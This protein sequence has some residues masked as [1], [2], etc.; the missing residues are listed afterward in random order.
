MVKCGLS[1]SIHKAFDWRRSPGLDGIQH[2]LNM[3]RQFIPSTP[4][5]IRGWL[6]A[7]RC[8]DCWLSGVLS[9]LCMK[10]IPCQS[11]RQAAGDQVLLKQDVEC[12]RD[13]RPAD[14]EMGTQ[15]VQCSALLC[16]PFV[17]RQTRSMDFPGVMLGHISGYGGSLRSER[18]V[19][20][21]YRRPFEQY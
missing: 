9:V 6:S 18:C 13:E 19:V 8:P 17:R 10:S 16:I 3:C 20:L 5:L 14:V 21:N 15:Y 4:L 11:I 7:N 12:L 2:G 1:T